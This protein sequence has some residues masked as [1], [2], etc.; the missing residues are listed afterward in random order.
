M[1]TLGQLFPMGQQ[2]LEPRGIYHNGYS[3]LKSA[4][5]LASSL[6]LCRRPSFFSLFVHSCVLAI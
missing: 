4:Y 2:Q 5:S 6:F 1:N 3:A